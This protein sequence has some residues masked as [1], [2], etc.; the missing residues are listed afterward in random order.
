MSRVRSGCEQVLEECESN[1]ECN[2]KRR[3]GIL[4]EVNEK[5]VSAIAEREWSRREEREISNELE[6]RH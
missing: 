1:R 2:V 5:K 6:C 4:S 3:D